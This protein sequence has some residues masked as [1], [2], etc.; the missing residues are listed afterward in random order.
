[1]YPSEMARRSLCVFLPPSSGPRNL[2]ALCAQPGLGGPPRLWL[3]A[4]PEAR[5]SP[6]MVVLPPEAEPPL[7]LAELLD[8]RFM[9]S[10]GERAR[11]ADHSPQRGGTNKEIGEQEKS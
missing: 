6:L 11:E 5:P 1:M 8:I 4:L 3:L 7:P 9:A 2:V 10:G